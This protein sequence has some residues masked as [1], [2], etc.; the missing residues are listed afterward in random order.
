MGYDFQAL[1]PASDHR[2]ADLL[3]NLL[4]AAELRDQVA[5][6]RRGSAAGYKRTLKLV[7]RECM[8][9][10]GV[11]AATPAHTAGGRHAKAVH[12]L[13]GSDPDLPCGGFRSFNAV[14]ISVL[15]DI[16]EAGQL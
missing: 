12:A 4:R 14:A 6:A 7:G 10:E 15:H 3:A 1:V 11:I 16:L 5:L 9:L 8:E 2:D 13:R